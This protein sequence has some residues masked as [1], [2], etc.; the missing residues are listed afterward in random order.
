MVDALFACGLGAGL[1]CDELSKLRVDALS[2]EARTLRVMGKGNKEVDQPIPVWVG[3]VLERWIAA[4]AGLGVQCASMFVQISQAGTVRDAGYS[5]WSVW[6]LV[7]TTGQAAGLEHFTTH[8]LRRTYATTLLEKHDL[9]L[10]QKLMRHADSST[11]ATYD[12]RGVAATAAAVDVLEAW[13]NETDIDTV[14]H[15]RKG[16]PLD[17]VWVRRQVRALR[18]RGMSP[19][20]TAGVLARVGVTDLDGKPPGAID[21]ARWLR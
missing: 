13:G 8:D 4:R 12:R 2:A 16:E 9:S 19:E 5:T 14:E 10:T 3:K 17:V 7:V 21:V 11:T 6:N 20:T 15:L 1:R 18:A